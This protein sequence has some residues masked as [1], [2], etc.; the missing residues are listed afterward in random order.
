VKINALAPIRPTLQGKLASPL[1]GTRRGTR[2]IL[3]QRT[4]YA[5]R[6]TL[7]TFGPRALRLSSE[8]SD[9]KQYNHFKFYEEL[10]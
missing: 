5:L 1:P 10:L 3:L 8:I 6:R 2:C 4:G 9:N 7:S